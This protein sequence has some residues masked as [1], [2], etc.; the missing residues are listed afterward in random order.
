[1]VK[2]IVVL[3]ST[4]FHGRAI[5]DRLRRHDDIELRTLSRRGTAEP[6]HFAGD[7]GNPGSLRG[8]VDGADVVIHAVSYVGGDPELAHRINAEG[9]AN[10]L[11][12]VAGRSQILYLSTTSVYGRGPHR[13][14]PETLQPRI[15][16]PLSS[17]RQAAELLVLEA[18]GTVIRP[19]LVYGN[20]D[21]WFIPGLVRLT[22][23]IGGQVDSGRALISVIDVESL[24]R[25][26]AQLAMHPPIDAQGRTFH[27]VNPTP[28]TVRRVLQECSRAINL[29]LPERTISSAEALVAAASLGITA[30]QLSLAAEDNWFDGVEAWSHIAADVVDEF[31]LSTQATAWYRNALPD[32]AATQP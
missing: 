31:R 22:R 23:G 11:Q 9:T 29:T 14:W 24:G 25:M 26:V 27:A 16:S 28:V 5:A 4:G 19:N 30:H 3:G 13:G 20:G 32:A 21:R 6:L 17:T 10:I 12:A 18:G 1:M 7:V 2:R 15:L 8:A